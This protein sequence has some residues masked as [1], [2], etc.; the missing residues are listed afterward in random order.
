MLVFISFYWKSVACMNERRE[1]AKHP[2]DVSSSRRAARYRLAEVPSIQTDDREQNSKLKVDVPS[3]AD[4][5]EVV[6]GD[7]RELQELQRLCIPPKSL[8]Q[9]KSTFS[10][11]RPQETLMN[12]ELGIRV[13]KIM[14]RDLCVCDCRSCLVGSHR[15]QGRGP[16]SQL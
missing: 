7:T 16:L 4:Q 15:R 10:K 14:H 9:T 13:C 5:E 6:N 2:S 3:Q 8:L 1:A 11:G 12:N